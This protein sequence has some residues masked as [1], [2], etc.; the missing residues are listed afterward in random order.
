MLST[1]LFIGHQAA[2]FAIFN[3]ILE[4]DSLHNF[5]FAQRF[6]IAAYTRRLPTMV[7]QVDLIGHYNGNSVVL[8]RVAL[9]HYLSHVLTACIGRLDLLR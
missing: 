4:N 3:E 2:Q 8:E 7:H 6:K 5:A 1:Y 9:D